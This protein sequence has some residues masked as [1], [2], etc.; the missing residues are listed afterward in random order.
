M[1]FDVA[2]YH[3]GALGKGQGHISLFLCGCKIAGLGFLPEMI[4][5]MEGTGMGN[6]HHIDESSFTP[7][8]TSC[9]R[10]EDNFTTK[11]HVVHFK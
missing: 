7:S 2:A 8:Q 11:I 3:I 5:R 4:E 6:P 10:K 1:G 9:L